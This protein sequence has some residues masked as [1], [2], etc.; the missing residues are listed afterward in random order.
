MFTEHVDKC[1]RRLGLR[2][3]PF[4]STPDTQ[5]FYPSMQHVTAIKHMQYGAVNASIS[6]ITGAIG[7]GKTLLCRTFLKEVQNEMATAYIFNPLQ[8]E[9]DLLFNIYHDLGGK[10]TGQHSVGEW[11]KAINRLV[12]AHAKNGKRSVIVV[13][14]AHRLSL[15]ALEVLRLLTNLE[16]ERRK[17]LT[18]IL[19]G[20]TEL[21][22][23]LDNVS[24][25]ALKQ[26]ISIHIRLKPL[27]HKEV[28]NYVKY[29]LSVAGAQSDLFSPAALKLLA[30]LSK[31]TPRIINKIAE[32]ALLAIYIKE[33]FQAGTRDILQSYNETKRIT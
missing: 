11:Y 25:F 29:R 15:R 32:R 9:Q 1:Y 21:E 10:K 16:T 3:N 26:R 17:L 27:S 19:V 14:E 2:T 8:S 22:A 23:K 28:G 12:I 31:G 6:L 4:S 7:T 24:L 30:F 20:Q 5:F 18:I 33:V 13:D